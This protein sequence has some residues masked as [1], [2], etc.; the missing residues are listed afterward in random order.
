MIKDADTKS[1]PEI[2]KAILSYSDKA[3]NGKLSIDEMQEAHLLF[4]M[5]EFL[6]L[7]SQRQFLMLRKQRY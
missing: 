2:E 7:C 5:V 3:R 1:L 6:V 4:Q